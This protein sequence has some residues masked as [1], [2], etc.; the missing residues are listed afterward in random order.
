MIADDSVHSCSNTTLPVLIRKHKAYR[1][2]VFLLMKLKKEKK[3]DDLNKIYIS[4]LSKTS[5]LS[6]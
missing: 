5:L 1:V 6:L 2:K 4:C 3:K